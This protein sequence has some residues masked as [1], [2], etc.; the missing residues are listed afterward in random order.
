MIL[1]SL[2]E[3]IK[4]FF[5]FV[6]F[7]TKLTSFRE[8]ADDHNRGEHKPNRDISAKMRHVRILRII[9]YQI[10]H[11]QVNIHIQE[12]SYIA[13]DAMKELDSRN[14][15]TILLCVDGTLSLVGR[16]RTKE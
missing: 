11:I 10:I 4:Q 13:S 5:A 16:L 9:L 6:H 3:Y 2:I 8:N 12:L 14:R 7:R 1:I 15:R